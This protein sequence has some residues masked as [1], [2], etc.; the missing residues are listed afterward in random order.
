SS[1]FLVGPVLEKERSV[2]TFAT[3]SRTGPTFLPGIASVQSGTTRTQRTGSL[4]T[5][6]S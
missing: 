4:S 6:S 5:P 3:T 1:S 2:P